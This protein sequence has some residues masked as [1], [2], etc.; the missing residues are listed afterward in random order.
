MV[1]TDPSFLKELCR[2]RYS[3]KVVFAMATLFFL[4]HVPYLFVVES[5][6]PLSVVVTLNIVGTAVIMVVSGITIR[7]CGQYEGIGQ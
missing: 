7:K 1:D 6:T 2:R 3:I 4:L 5:G